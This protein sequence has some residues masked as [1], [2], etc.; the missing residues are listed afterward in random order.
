M[1]SNARTR[2]ISLKQMAAVTRTRSLGA[3]YLTGK[4]KN[5]TADTLE[6]SAGV[7]TIQDTRTQDLLEEIL[8]E[9]KKHVP[10]TIKL[11]DYEAINALCHDLLPPC[12]NK[13]TFLDII[14]IETSATHKAA[15][16]AHPTWR[17]FL[18]Y[19]QLVLDPIDRF[20]AALDI[21]SQVAGTTGLLVWGSIRI[22]IQVKPSEDSGEPHFEPCTKRQGPR[23]PKIS[24]KSPRLSMTVSKI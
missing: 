11:Q 14:L 9:L 17:K 20:S 12:H 1:C 2:I 22:V 4:T 19:I 16:A 3:G 13:Q 15:A 10:K 18:H 23:L 7:L 8:S 6:K 5:A 24:G 21:L